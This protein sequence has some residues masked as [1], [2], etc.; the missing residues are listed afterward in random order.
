MKLVDRLKQWSAIRRVRP[1][2]EAPDVSGGRDAELLLKELVG[3]S[4]QSHSAYL[5]AGRRIP[6]KRQGR[7]REIDLIVCTPRMIH[8]IEVKN[9]SG[10]LEVRDGVWRQTR[11]NGE[12]VEH[13]DLFAGNRQRR[14]AVV[15]YLRDRGLS[16]AEPFLRD[17]IG[18]KVILMN[19]KLELER[20]VEDRPDVISRRELD[21]YL[22]R[23]P[24]RGRAERMFSTLI[25]LCRDRESRLAVPA[26]SAMMDIP[27]DQYQRMV[28]LLS[29]AGTWDRL[30]LHGTKVVMGD[31]LELAL[32]RKSYSRREL[33]E[34]AGDLPLRLH[35]TRGGALGLAKVVSGRGAL[36]VLYL[37]QTRMEVSPEDTVRFHAVGEPEPASRKLVEVNQIILG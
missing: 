28:A 1:V 35:W 11:R 18:P 12:V 16:L 36:G 25:E 14:D 32:G 9:W 13:P 26:K 8:L 5:F 4:F 21:D 6:S 37:G 30:H 7:R 34:R 17:H 33:E 10:R 24:E 23:R 31:L 22:G 2:H 3:A 29:Q 20:A 19:P 27:A 15:E